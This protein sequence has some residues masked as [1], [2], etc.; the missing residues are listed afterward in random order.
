MSKYDRDYEDFLEE[1]YL[2]ENIDE[3]NEKED[4][5]E[6]I[7]EYFNKDRFI[8]YTNSNNKEYLEFLFQ[9]INMENKEQKNKLLELLKKASFQGQSTIKDKI[10]Y[11]ILYLKYKY[12]LITGNVLYNFFNE[13]KSGNENNMNENDYNNFILMNFNKETIN[14]NDEEEKEIFNNLLI[15]LID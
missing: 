11:I 4:I 5:K 1:K 8:E 7:N 13:I 12:S 3:E 14:L 10:N 2:N 6:I 9:K 15:E